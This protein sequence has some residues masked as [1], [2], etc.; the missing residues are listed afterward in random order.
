MRYRLTALHHKL[1]GGVLLALNAPGTR[2]RKY[3]FNPKALKAGLGED[4]DPV[5]VA[6]GEHALRLD[7]VE[8]KLAALRNAHLSLK[9]RVKR[10]EQGPKAETAG[11]NRRQSS[12]TDDPSL[13]GTHADGTRPR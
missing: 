9:T 10:I 2:V 6:L 3:W 7:E 1:G 4:P 8:K 11:G 5:D 13:I 12:A